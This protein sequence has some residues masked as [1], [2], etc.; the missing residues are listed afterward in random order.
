M[1]IEQFYDKPLAHASYAIISDGKMAV[2]DPG[3]NPE[4]YY[5][6]AERHNA[7]IVAVIETH[8]HADFVSSHLQ[9]HEEKGAPIY[10]SSLTNSSYPSEA[11][12]DGAE[13]KLGSITLSALNT[14]GHSP[15]SI[16]IIAKDE[17]GEEVAAFT[18]D[19]LFIGD[20]GRPDLRENAGNVQAKRRELADM[21]YNSL[22]EKYSI[23]PNAMKVYPAHGAGSLCGKNLSSKRVSTIGEEKASNWS[24]QDMSKEEFAEQL[25]EGQ[26][27]IPHYFSHAVSLNSQGADNINEA[28]SRVNRVQAIEDDGNIVLDTRS[29]AEFRQGHNKNAINIEYKPNAKFETWLGAILKPEEKFHLIA[30]D[31]D[32]REK[33]LERIA[34]IGYEGNILTAGIENSDEVKEAEFDQEAFTNDMDSY[35]ILDVRQPGEVASQAIF[36]NAVSIPLAELRS[37]VDELD[38]S[39]P[40]VVHCAGGYRSPAAVCIIENAYPDATVIDMGS[41]IAQFKGNARLN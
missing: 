3:R 35:T 13:I 29:P 10:V 28:L 15:D 25:L 2:I 23:L 7:D 21:M 34:K 8:P 11:F 4:Q 32:R 24:L 39:K 33:V 26:P 40:I 41:A 6:F 9:I 36:D 20:C 12:D 31:A 22:R 30:A 19:T 16:T 27:F 18:G 17:N 14:P 38:R 37:R 5:A 1:H